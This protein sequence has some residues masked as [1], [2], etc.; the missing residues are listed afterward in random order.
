MYTVTLCHVRLTIFA[1]ETEQSSFGVLS[2]YLR[3]FQK[4]KNAESV[5]MEM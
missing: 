5:S 1:T 3:H 2:S 4:Y